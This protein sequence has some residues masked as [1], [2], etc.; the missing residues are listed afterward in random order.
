[1]DTH[2]SPRKIDPSRGS[3][4]GD[5]TPN[6]NDRVEIGPTP[7]A[8]AEWQ[9]AGLALPNLAR[10]R[11]HRWRKLTQALVDRD[12]G[13]L[14]MF[15]PLN[16]RYATD[17][18]NM[19]LWNSHNPF[20]A[21]LLCADGH[22]VLWDYKQAPFLATYN[23]L[24]AEIRH[25]ASFFYNVSGD[26]TQEHAQGF[27]AQVTEVM[28]AHAGTNRRL[29]VDKIMIHGLRAL[30]RAGFDVLEGEEVTERTRAIKGP[31]E[32]TAMRC[33]IHACEAAIAEMETAAREGIPRGGM[34]EDDVWAELHK[35]NIRRGGE[36]IETRL[37]ASGPRTN[38]WFQ[39]CG[40]RVIQNNEIVAFDTDL[41]G[42]Y[43]I[44]VDISRTWWIGDRPPRPDMISAMHHARDHIDTNMAMLKPGVRIR[45]LIHGG[46]TLA[47]QHQTQKYS[48]KMH[49]VGLCDEWPFVPYPDAGLDAA[50]DVE[51]AAGMVLCVEALVS[52]EGGDF[53]IKLEDQ[54]LVTETGVENLTRYGWDQGLMGAP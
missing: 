52:P 24:I 30:E 48:C 53:S 36:W 17:T 50:F 45:D 31:D 22:M 34:T 5:G 43:G 49:G 9:A 11:D 42:A 32:I 14:L 27:A 28:R 18:T 21:V 51:I 29:A 23:P 46:H 26:A 47:P 3:T 10:M 1:M 8:F 44:C 16:I 15:D 13:G 41:I 19:Q 33:A 6:D 4:V 20:R 39:E 37:L 25:G 2:R 7:L 35:G 38:P 12:I 40:P 54:V